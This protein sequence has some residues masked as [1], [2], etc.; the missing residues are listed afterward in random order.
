MN[1][2]ANCQGGSLS[3]GHPEFDVH[4]CEMKRNVGTSVQDLFQVPKGGGMFS[5]KVTSLDHQWTRDLK[6][7]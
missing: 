5:D 6:I 2:G 4:G 1:H 7:S 3:N